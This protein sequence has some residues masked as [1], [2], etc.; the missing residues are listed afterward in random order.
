DKIEHKTVPSGPMALVTLRH[1]L[2]VNDAASPAVVEKQTFVLLSSAGGAAKRETSADN[3]NTRHTKIVKPDDTMLFQYS[4]LG[5]NSHKIHLDRAHARDVEGLPDLVVNGGLTT[6]LLTEFLRR[7]IGLVPK[8][9]KAR[10]LAPLYS[11]R[12]VA[13][14]ALFDGARWI[15]SARDDAGIIA[16]SV[17]VEVQ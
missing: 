11:G 12:P 7:D 1:E 3:P 6:L 2:Q 14:A 17:E 10:Y 5:F 4:A 16:A 15:L 13:L 9:L 8:S